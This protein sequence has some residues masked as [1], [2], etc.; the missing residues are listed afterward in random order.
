MSKATL[1]S[2]FALALAAAAA[3]GCEPEVPAMPTYEAD[4]LPIFQ[5]RCIRC[6]G[7]TL[8][9]DPGMST[10][11]QCHLNQFLDSG[12]CT[13]AGLQAR[14]CIRGAQYCG[15]NPTGTGSLITSVI[16]APDN[17]GRMPPPPADPLSDWAKEVIDRWSTASPAER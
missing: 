12:D 3:A 9:A 8:R 4:V 2:V 16:H 10:P 13:P 14:L 1:A 6:H 7:E 11:T 15:T 5:A 17:L